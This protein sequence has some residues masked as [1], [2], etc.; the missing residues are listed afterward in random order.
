M[1]R[2]RWMRRLL[3]SSKALGLV[4]AVVAVFAGGALFGATGAGR[5][6]VRA[7]PNTW[8]LAMVK[9]EYGEAQARL[10]RID[11]RT[12]SFAAQVVASKLEDLRRRADQLR[13]Q[14]ASEKAATRIASAWERRW[15]G[16]GVLSFCVALWGLARRN[17]TITRAVAGLGRAAIILAAFIGGFWIFALP[18]NGDMG[19]LGTISTL[20]L[21]FIFISI[22]YWILEAWLS[23]SPTVIVEPGGWTHTRPTQEYAPPPPP[24]PEPSW[25][26][27]SRPEPP[28]SPRKPSGELL[29]EALDEL[30][31][32]V[33]MKEVKAEIQEM[34]AVAR[35]EP[36]WK[37]AGMPDQKIAWHMV[38]S[39]PPG[40]GKT[41]VARIVGKAMAGLGLLPSGH[42][43]EVDRAG[44]VAGYVGQTALKTQE[45][46]Q[47]AMG[48]VLFVD[49]AYTLAH[50]SEQ[51]FGHEA[52]ATLLKA[53]ED[54]RDKFCVIVAGYEEEMERFL[55]SNPGLRSRF[56]CKVRFRH[57]TP[58]ELIEIVRRDLER[59]G[60]RIDME[61]EAGEA[62][63]S[64]VIQAFERSKRKVETSS[65]GFIRR[66]DTVPS[67]FVEGDGRWAR[68]LV[69]R[70]RRAQ[71]KRIIQNPQ[72][73]AREIWNMDIIKA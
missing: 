58:E 8:R 39:G 14:G 15:K 45:A 20:I 49:E 53:M 6:A 60:F 50:E 52:I 7:F 25:D 9:A 19:W 36:R 12:R 51:D 34:I 29:K 65:A 31:H 55:D 66:E 5:G 46:I 11:A 62:L 26:Q 61:G 44:L 1:D 43:V 33:G 18:A 54:H 27:A 64:V 41:T 48:G 16:L 59:I 72:A 73:D 13:G 28:S 21:G 68:N 63:R 37:A 40:T 24:R 57:Y 3:P 67:G 47:R 30:N 35:A 32:L 42:V 23:P 10:E 2:F 70:I 17:R 22:G 38:F 71:A 56:G 4:L 69:E